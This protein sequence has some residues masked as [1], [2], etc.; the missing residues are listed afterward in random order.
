[1]STMS[2]FDISQ[3]GQGRV[4]CNRDR[5]LVIRRRSLIVYSK[6]EAMTASEDDGLYHLG[7]L[8]GL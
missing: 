4:F 2:I 1:M 7:Q 6:N 8:E 3:E 5:I